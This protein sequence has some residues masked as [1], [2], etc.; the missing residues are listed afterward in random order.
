MT[1]LRSHS[2]RLTTVASIALA[3]LAPS[4]FGDWRPSQRT[5]QE[6]TAVRSAVEPRAIVA[7]MNAHR[8][9]HGVPPL[10][11][12]D[13]LTRAA[14][15]RMDDMFARRYFDH[16]SPDGR[17]PF[18]TASRRGYRYLAIGEN[19]AFGQRSAREVVDAW[20]RSRGHRANILGRTYVDC[21]IAV[22]AGS[23][24]SRRNGGFTFVAL[25]GRE[26]VPPVRASVLGR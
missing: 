12:Q 23:P 5:D 1:R 2:H 26:R 21:G 15:D 10:R 18:Q 22:A 3:L 16:V 14:R 9:R 25:Y 20:M 11:L 8:R 4:A 13:E 17:G 6:R 19:L 7:E 24:L